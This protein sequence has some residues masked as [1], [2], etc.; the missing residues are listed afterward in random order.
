MSNTEQDDFAVQDDDEMKE[1]HDFDFGR[2]L[3]LMSIAEKVATV[4][5]KATS[6]LGIAQ[7]EL[8]VLNTQA[9]DIARRRAD[10]AR[11]AEQRKAEAAAQQAQAEA[12]EA[13]VDGE[14]DTRPH[15]RSIPASRVDL[16][17]GQPNGRR[18]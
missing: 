14:V 11:E 15:A 16:M 12:D 9:K 18:V 5:P 2:A 3:T 13:D 6:L 8:D 17:P 4:A 10:R 1:I 7:A